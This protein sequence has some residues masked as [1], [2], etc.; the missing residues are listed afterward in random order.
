M[1]NDPIG[2]FDS[3]LGGLNVLLRCVRL[4]PN[5]RYIYLADKANMPYGTKSACDVRRA[6]VYCAERLF[7]M[8]CKAVLIACNTATATAVDD[9]RALF[10]TRVVVG[11]E[12]AVKPCYRELGKNGYA[13]ALV[14]E[15]TYRSEKFGRLIHSCDGKIVPKATPQLAALIEDGAD[16]ATLD[17]Y[18]FGVLEKHK[19]AEAVILGC[20]HYTYIADTVK[21]FYG[22]NIKI[23][24]GADGAAA[25]LQY[26]L[27][28]ADMTSDSAEL[29][30]KIMFYSTVKAVLAQKVL[31]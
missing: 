1:R 31:V 13:V 20:S 17:R 22:G 9:I 16:K 18:I 21:R 2:I 8:N 3:G 6:A 14:T 26:C 15:A 30:P 25:R 23:Y 4:M 11:L 5:E 19:K 7:G 10:G 29:T 24:D 27:R 12:P 28:L